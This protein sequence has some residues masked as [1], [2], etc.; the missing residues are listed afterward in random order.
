VGK[1]LVL[2]DKL[3]LLEGKVQECRLPV[4]LQ[5]PSQLS[6]RRS[7][8][9]NRYQALLGRVLR[10]QREDFTSLRRPLRPLRPLRLWLQHL[11]PQTLKNCHILHQKQRNSHRSLL[12][13]CGHQHFLHLHLSQNGESDVHS[14]SRQHLK[15]ARR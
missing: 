7:Q 14:R 10:R 12:P 15:H 8:H 3:Q 4:L 1:V 9:L 6:L 5:R 13:L 11:S 2:L